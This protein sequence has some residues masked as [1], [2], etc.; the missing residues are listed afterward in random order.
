M[1]GSDTFVAMMKKYEQD[2]GNGFKP[3]D[4]KFARIEVLSDNHVD[5]LAAQIFLYPVPD[6]MRI[7]GRGENNY[8]M[9]FYYEK[10]G[11]K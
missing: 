9:L 1:P 10:E 4:K 7:W 5:N 11:E 2:T 8:A 3:G 6:D